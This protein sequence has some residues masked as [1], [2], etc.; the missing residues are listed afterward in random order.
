MECRCGND[1]EKCR[2]HSAAWTLGPLLYSGRVVGT[3]R[4]CR[5]SRALSHTELDLNPSFPLVSKSLNCFEPQ[6]P[7]LLEEGQRIAIISVS[8]HL[9]PSRHSPLQHASGASSRGREARY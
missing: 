4:F 9:Q 8:A 6:F 5:D 2:H 7:N 3:H 1:L